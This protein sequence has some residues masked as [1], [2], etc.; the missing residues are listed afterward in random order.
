[1]V[2]II[3]AL[4]EMIMIMIHWYLVKKRTLP[5]YIFL[6]YIM[7]NQQIVGFPQHIFRPHLT[8]S[9]GTLLLELPKLLSSLKIKVN[10]GILTL[11]F[12]IREDILKKGH[13]LS[14]MARIS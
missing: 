14:S 9:F 3:K 6:K 7:S 11:F 1:M 5:R 12:C 4:S 10:D 2:M 8:I 13:L